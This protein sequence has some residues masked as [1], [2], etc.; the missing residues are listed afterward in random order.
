MRQSTGTLEILV[1]GLAYLLEPLAQRLAAGEIRSLLAE[2]GLQFPAALETDAA[3]IHSTQAAVQRVQEMSLLVEQLDAAITSDNAPQIVTKALELANAVRVVIE[4][5]RKIAEALKRAGVRSE[6]P[7][8]ELHQFTDELPGRLLE[9]LVVRQ[10][11]TIPGLTEALEFI[12]GLDRVELPAVDLQHPAFVQRRIHV[13]QLMTFIQKPLEQLKRRYQWGASDFDGMRLFET[14]QR[15]LTKAGVP[16]VLDTSGP[17]PV[18]DVLVLEV[19]PKIDVN[20]PGL[21]IKITDTIEVD[22]TVP[23]QQDDWELRLVQNAQLDVGV[24]IILQPNDDVTFIPLPEQQ[25]QDETYI[26]WI[27][28]KPNGQPYLILGQTGGSRVEARQLVVRA[29]VGFG[30]N[31]ANSRAEGALSLAGELRHG[32]FVIDLAGADGFLGKILGG[33]RLESDF[34]VGFGFSSREGIFFQGSSTLEIQLPL[35]V[36]LGP[37]DLNRLTLTVGLHNNAFP[38]GL[39]ADIKATLGPLQAIVEQ[40]GLRTDINLPADH[41]GN[42]GPV[43]FGMAFKPPKGAGL[44]LDTGVVKGG[45]YLFFDVDRQEYA[46]VLELYIANIVTTKA[47]GL[48]TTRI[49]DSSHEGFSLLIVMNAEFGTGIQLG[50]GFTLLS[51]GGLLGLNRT[52][53][54]QPLIESVRTGAINSIMFPQNPL[55][56]APQIIS[57]LRTLFPPSPGKFLIGSMAKL[58]WGTPTLIRVSL[59]VIIEIPGNIAIL[60]KLKVT[61]PD[62]EAALIVIQVNF[63]GTIEVDKKRLYFFAT[64]FESRVLFITL[65]GEMGLLVA[66]GDKANF[67]LSVGG[68]HPRFNPPPLPF[69]SPRRIALDLLNTSAYRLRVEGYF[70]VTSNTVQFGAR[71]ELKIKVGV[72]RVQGH[73]VFDALFQFS[74]FH[75]IIEISAG[76]S[77]KVRGKGV[78]SI[79]LQFAL[80]GPALWRAHGTGTLS[81]LCFDFSADFDVTW[82]EKRDTTLPALSVMPLLLSELGKLDNWTA[83]LPVGNNL[84]VSLRKLP[85][86]EATHV[87]H[88]L[89]RLRVSQRLVPLDM[90]IDKVG[91]QRLSD[92]D[93]FTFTPIEGLVKIT[94]ADEQFAKAQF[95]N[96]SDAAKLSRRAFDPLHSGIVLSS[97]EQEL[98]AAKLA[99]RRVRY[100]RIIIDNHFKRARQRFFRL[101]AGI[102]GH[103]IKGA[104]ITQ[105]GLSQSYKTQ[106]DPFATKVQV[107]PG[108]FTVA[109]TENNQ[110]YSPQA[111]YFA[112]ETLA[113]QFIEEKV[114]ENPQLYDTLHVIPQQETNLQRAA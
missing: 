34:N 65:E 84:L 102:F 85:S 97:G 60:G 30:W 1:K 93:E 112:S 109:F 88:P 39:A 81:L 19:T 37:V 59:G 9:Y 47:I 18:L 6:I 38:I 80:E 108:G 56:N 17:V 35:H 36:N 54:L 50:L 46:G 69:P 27:G 64:L 23:F 105:S 43:D 40:M 76:V 33:A 99:K 44:S 114:R 13:D 90:R 7:E 53:N 5:I 42:I 61:L 16:S 104:A 106:L 94:D 77:F 79:S 75:F 57:D 55:A 71:T 25:V 89:G 21:R 52:M 24:Q 28:G 92:A 107:K 83:E 62:E 41:Q 26:E 15:L 86:A 2:L 95:V 78:F 22:N 49:P 29:G 68:F 100:E 96:M 98:G 14:I 58:G 3:L 32:R 8:S 103:F 10:L 82:G 63:A 101:P 110:A 66:W 91:N 70:A 51:L 74:P 45:G 11:E 111:A 72:G 31:A 113:S 4:E 20:P 67:V 73:I 48:I 12:G 87:L